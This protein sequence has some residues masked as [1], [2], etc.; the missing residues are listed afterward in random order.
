MTSS[1]LTI[2]IKKNNKT[3][4]FSEILSVKLSQFIGFDDAFSPESDILRHNGVASI[5]RSH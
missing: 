5:S 4:I 1:L 2:V 3:V